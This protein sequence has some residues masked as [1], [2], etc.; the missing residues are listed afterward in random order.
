MKWKLTGRFLMAMMSIVILVILVNTAM[1]IYLLIHESSDG[2]ADIDARSAEDF[3]RTLSTYMTVENDVPLLNEE[4]IQLLRTRQAWIQFLDMNGTA[5]MEIDA[6]A[7]ARS[8]YRPI[9]IVQ[10]YKYREHDTNTTVFISNF[11]DFTYLVGI[12]DAA[13]ARTVLAFNANSVV[14]VVSTYLLYIVIL[15]LV[16]AFIVGLLF[17]SILTKPLSQMMERIVQMKNHD[18]VQKP[19]KRPGIYK[20]V[21]NNIQDVSQELQAQEL[22]RAKLEQMRN[23]WMSN[24]SHDMKTPL[25]SI[26]GYAEL[27][28]GANA[29]EQREY[30]A[31]IEQKSIYMR[32]LLDDFNLTMRLRNDQ[33][34][35]QTEQVRLEA[36]VREVVIDVLNNPQFDMREVSFD[37]TAGRLECALDTHLMK[38]AITNFI[39]NALVHNPEAQVEVTLRQVTT[40]AV[41]KIC[42]NGKGMREE[43]IA[44]VFE[45]YY[46]GKN[47]TDI[48]GTGLGTAIARDIITAHGGAV[49][50]ESTQGVGTVV[51]IT[52]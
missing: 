37:S 18:F 32:E 42:D 22:E 30:A 1:L 6:P 34:P 11:G 25:A 19:F 33:M 26:Q 52:L 9:D 49:T 17:S 31:I 45:R 51:T 38:R 27:L 20:Q 47:T 21:F 40:R 46:R 24:V 36:F 8:H 48:Q 10:T 15:D 41:I 14:Q 3:T 35:L 23:E 39:V 5:V 16:I 28:H 12:Q 29:Q 43:D 2:L 4:G 13:V 44:Q 7:T 50:L